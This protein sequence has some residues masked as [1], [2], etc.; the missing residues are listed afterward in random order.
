MALPES[1]GKVAEGFR[2]VSM[3]I[4]RDLGIY[5]NDFVMIVLPEVARDQFFGQPVSA[6]ASAW[7]PEVPLKAFPESSGCLQEALWRL[8]RGLGRLQEVLWGFW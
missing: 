7:A 3:R 4:R 2:R 5:S 8:Q 6:R 1:S